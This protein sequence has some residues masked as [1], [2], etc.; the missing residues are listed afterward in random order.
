MSNGVRSR[1]TC[2]NQHHY[3]LHE[4]A[5]RSTARRR[6]VAAPRTRGREIEYA[7][8]ALRHLQ[9]FTWRY[10]RLPRGRDLRPDY[11][12]EHA[13]RG[14]RDDLG[15]PPQFVIRARLQQTPCQIERT[16]VHSQK[17][18]DNRSKVPLVGLLEDVGIG[19]ATGRRG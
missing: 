13:L 1:R 2:T 11:I 6:R 14:G 16:D 17:L 19:G 12:E 7:R 15:R 18:I 9:P 10:A 8:R 5:A 3:S 4:L